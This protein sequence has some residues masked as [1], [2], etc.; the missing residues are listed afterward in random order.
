VAE[1][2]K[3]PDDDNL[4]ELHEGELI[5]MPPR[6]WRQGMVHTAVLAALSQAATEAGSGIVLGRCGF[7][8]APEV[9][10]APDVA[11]IRGGTGSGDHLG[12]L[13]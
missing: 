5:V 2:G 6:G 7:R 9:V 12:S 8:L 11:F 10:Q 3:L 1:F 13:L 4:Q